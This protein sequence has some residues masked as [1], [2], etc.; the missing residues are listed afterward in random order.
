MFKSLKTEFTIKDLSRQKQSQTFLKHRSNSFSTAEIALSS[1]SFESFD[2]FAKPVAGSA[3]IDYMIVK[4]PKAV[5]ETKLKEKIGNSGNIQTLLK[6]KDF[7]SIFLAMNVSMYNP[8][9]WKL[10]WA[11]FSFD[12]GDNNIELLS[13]APDKKGIQMTIKKTGSRK[14]SLSLSGELGPSFSSKQTS[15][16]D[17][18]T[19]ETS[20][21]VGAKIGGKV[22]SDFSNGWETSYQKSI[23]EVKGFSAR[24]KNG[25]RKITWEL[26]RNKSVFIPQSDMGSV[27]VASSSMLVSA[28]KNHVQTVHVTIDGE[29]TGKLGGI[30]PRK[31]KLQ[32]DSIGS[33]EIQPTL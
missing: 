30:I 7:F 6:S 19:N 31:G 23:K 25:G 8:R 11:K 9:Q 14:V 16:T 12:L 32:L 10:S 22:G 26:T 24:K 4:T 33:F 5:V 1:K 2:L 18:I 27:I 20:T 28:K 21:S 13:H 15:K 3:T 17:D 29:T